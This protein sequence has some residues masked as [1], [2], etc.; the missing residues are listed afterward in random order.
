MSAGTRFSSKPARKCASTPLPTSVTE[1]VHQQP[2]PSTGSGA[3]LAGTPA[4]SCTS[5]T[6]LSLCLFVFSI[7]PAEAQDGPTKNRFA[8]GGE[9]KIKTSDRASQE[10]YARGQ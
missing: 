6:W 9:F 4:V 3:S 7:V 8:I 1:S 5:F 2:S 10:D